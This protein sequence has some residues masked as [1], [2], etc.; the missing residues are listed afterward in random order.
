MIPHTDGWLGFCSRQ[1]LPY[2]DV[3]LESSFSG[4]MEYRKVQS[5]DSRLNLLQPI[6]LEGVTNV[7]AA[8]CG[9][10]H[11][12]IACSGRPESIDE[13]AQL[14]NWAR[15]NN[16]S[17]IQSYYGV[18]EGNGSIDINCCDS[19]GRSALHIATQNGFRNIV[20]LLLQL[21]ANSD[22]VDNLGNSSLHYSFANGFDDISQ[23]LLK[24]GADDLKV[25]DEGL[26]CYEGASF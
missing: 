7:S 3:D 8:C 13:S 17:E 16:Y 19:N 26:T 23:L 18:E 25:N 21:G 11:L 5:F 10:S 14:L 1:G 4:S 6:K 2:A 20:E 22:A 24:Y 12:L 9:G 15:H